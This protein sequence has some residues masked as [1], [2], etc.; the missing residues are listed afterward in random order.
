[1]QDIALQSAVTDIDARRIAAAPE[2]AIV[3]P[4][5]NERDN[6]E[7]LVALLAEALPDVAWEV[8]FVD[9]DSTD[10]TA[11]LA[12][13]LAQRDL[14]VRCLQRIGR[15][16]LASACI[17][18][19]LASASPYVAVMDGDLQHDERLLGRMLE[20]LRRGEFD[21]VVGSRYVA[22][23][24][25]GDGLSDRR[26]RASHLAT[27]LARLVCKAQIADP[28]SGFFMFRRDVFHAAVRRLSGEGFKIL[29]DLLASS[30]QHLRVCE[31]P[32]EFRK[33]RYG[34]S[35]LDVMVVWEYG[36]LLADKMI[37]HLV[38]VRFALFA[39]I[40]GLGLF[41]HL[42]VLWTGLKLFS[43]SF[44]EAQAGAVVTAMTSNFFLNNFFTYRDKRLHRWQLVRGLVSFY[45][46]CSLGAVANVGLASYV[47]RI[48]QIWWLA[49]IA[50]VIVGSVWNYAISSVYTWRR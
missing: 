23:G 42:A 16:G 7:P 34:E 20:R 17:E 24:A 10:G 1:M 26:A 8:I 11:D 27:R 40:G 12:R 9:D 25:V 35:K 46:I 29:L 31:I 49:G 48:D 14:R 4:T 13:A 43:L 37:G 50:G 15:R 39:L 2:L 18:G 22:D 6:L 47:F 41:V 3:I 38:P 33:R 44:L 19:I 30:P 21:L 45:A 5:L 28:M 36:M 32:F